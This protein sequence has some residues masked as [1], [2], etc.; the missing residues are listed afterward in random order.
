MSQKK[1]ITLDYFHK[2][3]CKHEEGMFIGVFSSRPK[4]LEAIDRH[5]ALPGFKENP[6]GFVIQEYVVDKQ[7]DVDQL[8]DKIKR[9]AK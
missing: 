9:T 5:S 1:L 3:E 2:F 6:N 4:A 8:I 7:P